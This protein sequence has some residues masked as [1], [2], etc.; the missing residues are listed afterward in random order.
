DLELYLEYFEENYHKFRNH[1]VP[2]A[3]I[4]YCNTDAGE[5]QDLFEKIMD[6]L[7]S[8]EKSLSKAHSGKNRTLKHHH[9]P[10]E[11]D[12]KPKDK[13]HQNVGNYSH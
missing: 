6:A 1:T 8:L 9:P 11:S 3:L 5:Q 4:E 13:L 2:G 10:S 7:Q 12:P